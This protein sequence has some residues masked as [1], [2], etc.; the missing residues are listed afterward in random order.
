MG[1][2]LALGDCV[3]IDRG[4]WRGA[5]SQLPRRLDSD[6]VY[7]ARDENTTHAYSPTSLQRRAAAD[8]ADGRRLNA[9]SMR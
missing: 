9:P 1:I 5:A 4:A 6:L 8:C 3:S 2:Y 7:L